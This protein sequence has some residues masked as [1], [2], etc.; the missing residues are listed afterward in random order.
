MTQVPGFRL[1]NGVEIPQLGFGV[2]QVPPDETARIV[3][4]AFAAGYRHIDTAQ[5]YRNEEGVGRAIA[6]SG[7]ARDEV[8]VTTKLNN[9]AHGYDEAIAALEDSLTK[10]RL[11]HVDLFLIHWPLPHQDRYVDTWKGFEKLLAD[12]KTRAIG[13]S[14]FQPAHLDRLAAGT[15]T[16][17]S[18]NQIELHPRLTQDELRK[19]HSAHGIATEAW[20]PIAK[21]EVLD[22]PTVEA[23]AQ[24]YDRTPAQIVLRWH[25]QIGNVVIPKSANPTRMRENFDV[26]GFE[27]ADDDLAEIEALNEDYRTGPHPDTFGR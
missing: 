18:V 6:D 8:F 10:L 3:G 22:H 2:F 16:V 19:Y 4:E 26:F 1:N 21:G 17:P 15:D 24:K 9:G 23:L 25:L 12:G 7:L 11:D 5:M 20:S 13:V 14:N 27:L